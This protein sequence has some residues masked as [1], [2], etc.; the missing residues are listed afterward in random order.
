[1]RHFA[2]VREEVIDWR[3]QEF[4]FNTSCYGCH[5]SQFENNYDLETDTYRTTW[6]EPGI[7]SM[8]LSLPRR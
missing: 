8:E 5:V 7:N 3:E 4:T 2:D 1:M 6:R